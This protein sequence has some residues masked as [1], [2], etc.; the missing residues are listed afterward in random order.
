MLK[1]LIRGYAYVGRTYPVSGLARH[2]EQEGHVH[3]KD[4]TKVD[5]DRDDNINP[6]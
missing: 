5:E 6:P 1:R 3:H 4:H 2:P